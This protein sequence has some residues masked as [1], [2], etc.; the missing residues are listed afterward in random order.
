MGWG[1][2]KN[3][4]GG[5]K[6]G[7]EGGVDAKFLE[8]SSSR[9]HS[10]NTRMAELRHKSGTVVTRDDVPLDGYPV[11][12]VVLWRRH[13]GGRIITAAGG[14]KHAGARLHVP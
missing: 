11:P 6:G 1:G 4:E 5:V 8:S 3:L 2:L 10:L 13:M 9:K 14:W 7:V 12:I